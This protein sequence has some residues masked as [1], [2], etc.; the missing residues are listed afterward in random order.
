[1]SH[2]IQRR[3]VGMQRALAGG[4][5]H[6]LDVALES[7]GRGARVDGRSVPNRSA[8]GLAAAIARSAAGTS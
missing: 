4:L 6:D 1:M 8:A 5:A 7:N 3:R 2:A